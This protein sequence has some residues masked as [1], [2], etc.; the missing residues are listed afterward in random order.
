[1]TDAVSLSAGHHAR[2][3]LKNTARMTTAHWILL[4]LVPAAYLIGSIPFGLIVGLAKGVDPR[5]AGSGNIGATNIGRLLGG[6][7]F[8]LV[9]VLDLLKGLVPMLIAAWIVR[10]YFQQPDALVYLLWLL[11]GFGAIVG[12]MFSF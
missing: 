11:V 2:Y 8:A 7:F 9:F 12:H 5:K 10:K 3:R 1:M 6:K 4:S